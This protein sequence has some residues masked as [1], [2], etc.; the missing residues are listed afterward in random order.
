M[1]IALRMAHH[2][3]TNDIQTMP[4]VNHYLRLIVIEHVFVTCRWQRIEMENRP[5]TLVATLD[6]LQ[7]ELYPNIYTCLVQ[8]LTMPV[9]TCTAERS[10]SAHKRIKTYLRAGMGQE[11]FKLVF[12]CTASYP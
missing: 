3:C 12:A 2:N 8:L 5:S 9:T 1:L 11:R 10:F 7:P 6:A 4:E